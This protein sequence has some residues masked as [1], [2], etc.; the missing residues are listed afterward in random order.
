MS[1]KLN[2][3][4]FGFGVVGQGLYDIVKTKKLN[5]EIVKFAI[6]DPTKKRSLPAHLFTTDKEELLNNPE[7]N[8][9]VELIND[10]E[11]AFEIVSRALKSGKN[12]VSASKKMI[13]LHLDELIEIQHQYGTSL[14]YEGA[15][16]GSIP[17]IRNLEEYYDNELLHSISGI[18]NGSSNYILSKGFIEGLDYDSALKQA[19]DLGFAETDPT[20]DVGGFDAKYKL[21]IAAAHAYGVVVQPDEVFNLGIQNLAA[22]DLQYAREKNLKI[23]LVPVAKELDDRNVALFVLPKFVNDKEFLYNVEYEYNGVTVQAAFADQQFFFGKGAGGHPT[24]SAVLSDIAA[25]RYNYQYEYK[26]AKEKTDLN[27]TNNIELTVYL[28]YDDEELVEALNFEHINERYYSGNYKF[29]IGK[30]NLQNLIANQQRIS[31][32]KAFVAFADQLTGVSLASA[33]KQTA[34]VF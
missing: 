14:L 11:A 12:V 16:C 3:G 29:V 1:K 6:K 10:T 34:E 18:F 22:A 21:V 9:I 2:I 20:S 31:D 30:I 19:Q 5:I 27:F 28:R 33:A 13:A 7:I 32:S 24:G 26:K 17:I 15:V 23:K 4:L 25:L 8:T